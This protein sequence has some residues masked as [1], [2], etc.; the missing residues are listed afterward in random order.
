MYQHSKIPE[1]M[2][3]LIRAFT[4]L[5]SNCWFCHVQV[6]IVNVFCNHNKLAYLAFIELCFNHYIFSY[7]DVNIPPPFYPLHDED[8]DKPIKNVTSCEFL[9]ILFLCLLSSVDNCLDQD[10]AR[11]KVPTSCNFCSLLKMFDLICIQPV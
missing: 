10:Q 6:C 1:Q 2:P 5:T 3:R 9:A 4:S 11:Q 8:M 7:P